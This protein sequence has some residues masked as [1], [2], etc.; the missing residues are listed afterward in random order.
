LLHKIFPPFV[1]SGL[2]K[3]LLTNKYF[4][5]ISHFIVFANYS[6]F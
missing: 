6:L 2:I 5:K 3:T 1:F 4:I